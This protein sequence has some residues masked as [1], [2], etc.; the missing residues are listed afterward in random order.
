[1]ITKRLSKLSGIIITITLATS[2]LGVFG[3]T[4]LAASPPNDDF[5]QARAVG[6]LPFSDTV[7]TTDATAAFDD[8][9]DCTNNG[10]VWYKFNP[11]SD[12]LLQADTFGSNYDTVLSVYTGSRGAL[13][14]NGCNDDFNGL[15]SRVVFRA[16]GGTTYYLLIAN[17]CGTG[18]TGGGDLHLSLHT[19]AP[20]P[21]D[22]FG[23][24]TA[25][26]TLPFSDSAD[27]TGATVQKGEPAP[28]GP[29]AASVWYAF[30][31]ATSGSIS[32]HL[33]GSFAPLLAVYTGT[34]LASLSN[35]GCSSFGQPLTFHANAGTTYYFQ[36]GDLYGQDST[37]QF[38]LDTAPAPVAG[39]FFN[40]SD[41]SI[42]DTIQFFD[43]SSDPGSVGFQS[44]E[45]DFGDRATATGCCVAH[46]YAADGDYTVTL[47]VTTMDGRSASTTQVVHVQTHDVG[48]AKLTA[49]KS[50]RSGR[51]IRI[52]VDVSNKRYPETVQVQLLRSSAG[53]FEVVGTLTQFVQA[54]QKRPTTFNFSYT[55]TPND[56][57][58][59]KVTFKAIATIVDARDGFPSDNE[60]VAPSTKVSR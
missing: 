48:I 14:L 19:L 51:S 6:A 47:R 31:P 60:V 36:V 1:M 50:G 22:N 49:P 41:P 58:I 4:A 8:P 26:G 12:V 45:W 23:N 13:T 52:T 37:L 33:N 27:I 56:A 30:R 21:N 2:F 35:V 43:G 25:I 40:P 24:A 28:C 34:S 11:S 39:F 32:A 20:P 9:T 29:L 42:F 38:Q 57:N 17:C 7:D 16:T 53:G 18:G 5:D 15:Q 55:F 44:W 46:R 59:G 10:S 54:R 3:G